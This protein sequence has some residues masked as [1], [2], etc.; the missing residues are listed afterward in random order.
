MAFLGRNGDGL[1][2][3]PSPPEEIEIRIDRWETSAEDRERMARNEAGSALPA[4]SAPE[5][6]WKD[7]TL[8]L[9][10]TGTV[11][12]DGTPVPAR[13]AQGRVEDAGRDAPTF[14]F[15]L[16]L[17]HEPDEG[18]L[19]GCGWG[20]RLALF[21]YAAPGNASGDAS[22]DSDHVLVSLGEEADGS[23]RPHE[24]ARVSGRK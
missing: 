15:W 23:W 10:G 6:P 4:F 16:L 9:L 11:I 5:G 22:W 24:Y 3:C 19:A 13:F 18:P 14:G 8:E 17:D 2:S 12:I 21:L 7:A 20:N 1:A